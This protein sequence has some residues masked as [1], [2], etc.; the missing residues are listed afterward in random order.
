MG[1]TG[2]L[3]GVRTV[4]QILLW[5]ML[6]VP[7][8]LAMVVV[9]RADSP[10]VNR[11]TAWAAFPALFLALVPP[12]QIELSWLLLGSRLGVDAVGR[13]FL[14]V[15]AT[16]WLAAG[17]YANAYLAND[18]RR[19][20]FQFFFLLTMT[21]NLG[22]TVAQDGASFLAFFT[23]MSLAAYGLI[24]H[25]HRAAST[26]AG[27]VYMMMTIG[28]EMLLFTGLV[29]AFHETGT[30][31]FSDLSTRLALS[32]LR[33]IVLGLLLAGLGIK[34]GVMPFHGW[35]PMAH[36]AAPTPASAVLSGAMIKT[37]LLGCLRVLPLGMIALPTWSD[38]CLV[39][40]LLTCLL[41]ALIGMSQR[42]PKAV[43]AYSSVSQ[44][45]LVTVCLGAALVKPQA[46]PAIGSAL[47]V[48]VVHHGVAKAALFL[49]IGIAATRI[50]STAARYLIAAG[51]GL[52]ALSLAGLPGTMGFAAK[53]AL[54]YS[55]ANLES[56]ND[57][58]AWLLPLTSVT[59]TLLVSRYLWL[60]WPGP[61]AGHG[62]LSPGMVIPWGGLSVTVVAGFFVMRW[63][64]LVNPAWTT[65][66]P[67]DLWIAVWPILI[68]GA[69]A[70]TVILVARI[71]PTNATAMLAAFR[72]PEGDLVIPMIATIYRLRRR[73]YR[74][75]A[76]R[77]PQSSRRL[78]QALEETVVPRLGQWL[79]RLT[80]SLENDLTAG[81]LLV[82][83]AV[84]MLLISL[85]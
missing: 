2:C 28:G 6:V 83:L 31:A 13:V 76:I 42:N 33:D 78:Q 72:I 48:W 20:A 39:L 64:T 7:L 80:R 58:L 10:L 84:T 61:H 24:I 54:K 40:G 41:A 70:G 51:L 21:G 57:A 73:W 46:W 62:R 50:P 1:K 22:V 74:V 75:T 34:L 37:G 25:D 19:H 45:G 29:I 85:T 71:L 36:P 53:T 16:L 49:G 35:L 26:R 14:G 9:T 18:A 27:R 30:L 79:D 67:S 59:T 38:I 69:L 66:A 32:P 77:L 81:L 4:N 43:L 56:W 47:M 63:Q 52:A 5:T 68:A 60:V 55:T 3:A 82:L 15:T 23:L 11:L 17:W 65:L 8:V 44:M 12:F